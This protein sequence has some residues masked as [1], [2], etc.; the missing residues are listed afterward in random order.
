M[1]CACCFHDTPP[2]D[3]DPQT[4]LLTQVQGVIAEYERAKIAERYRRGKLWR[5]RAGEV[6][7]LE[8]PPM[9]IGVARCAGA[10]PRT[11]RSTNPKRRSCGASSR[12]MSQAMRRGRSSQLNHDHVPSPGAK[13]SGAP[14]RSTGVLRNEAYVGRAYYN[15][16]IHPRPALSAPRP[17]AA[18]PAR[19]VDRHRGSRIVSEE[20]FDAA[21]Q[22]SRETRNGVRAGSRSAWLLRHVLKCGHCGVSVAAMNARTQRHLSSL[23]LLP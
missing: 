13:R 6:I 10:G 2:L 11:S 23:L 12:T 9:A 1:A 22:V 18:S 4:H 20:L 21:Q 8:M 15:R 17:P 3:D 14:R 5:A 19:T 16:R 7:A